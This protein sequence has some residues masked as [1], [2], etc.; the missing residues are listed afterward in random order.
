MS[1][2]EFARQVADLLME[3]VLKIMVI[4]A[5]DEAQRGGR[6]L[7]TLAG[8]LDGSYLVDLTPGKVDV[9]RSQEASADG[10]VSWRVSLG[11]V[12][13]ILQSGYKF[14]KA[15]TAGQLVIEADRPNQIKLERA[16]DAMSTVDLPA[17]LR[18]PEKVVVEKFLGTMTGKPGDAKKRKKKDVGVRI[19]K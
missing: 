7:F 1:T 9:K 15:R 11:D 3:Q 16:L 5:G 8:D 18:D 12:A 19:R 14:A 10:R 2:D 17:C 6:Y 4:A 13:N